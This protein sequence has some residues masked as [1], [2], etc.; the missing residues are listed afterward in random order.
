MKNYATR[1]GVLLAI[2]TS[3]SVITNFRLEKFLKSI[4]A[5]MSVIEGL[6]EMNHLEYVGGLDGEEVLVLS[7][8]GKE[9]LRGKIPQVANTSW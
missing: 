8:E 6:L 2:E 1:I 7:L 3:E 5:D 4:D 9:W